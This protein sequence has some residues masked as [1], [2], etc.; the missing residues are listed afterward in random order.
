MILYPFIT[1]QIS[2][3]DLHYSIPKEDLIHRNIAKARKHSESVDFH[4][5]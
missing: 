3:L 4:L 5:T 1:V 2:S